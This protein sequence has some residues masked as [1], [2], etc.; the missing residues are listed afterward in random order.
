[1]QRLAISAFGAAEVPAGI[2]AAVK[3]I[4]IKTMTFAMS[5]PLTVAI[6]QAYPFGLVLC[7]RQ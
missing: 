6:F 5:G 2:S 4:T 1:M 7:H 3:K